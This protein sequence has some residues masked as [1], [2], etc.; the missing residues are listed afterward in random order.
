MRWASRAFA[1]AVVVQIFGPVEMLLVRSLVHIRFIGCTR[2]PI[3]GLILQ[4]LS[5]RPGFRS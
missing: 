4:V 1:Q 2:T 3:T 5:E